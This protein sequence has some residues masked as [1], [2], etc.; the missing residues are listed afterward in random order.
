MK[1]KFLLISIFLL[2][3]F[4]ISCNSEL[5]A[6]GVTM[7]RNQPYVNQ[8]PNGNQNVNPITNQTA[9]D[10][11]YSNTISIS[12]EGTNIYP[13]NY[14]K[15]DYIKWQTYDFGTEYVFNVETSSWVGTSPVES[16]AA[17]VTLKASSLKIVNKLNTPINIRLK[18]TN[19]S[20][21]VTVEANSQPVKLSLDNLDLV[22]SDRALNIKDSS[23]SYIVLT[24]NNSLETKINSEDKN[25]IKSASNLIFDGS[26]SLTVTANSK[27][28]IA[29]DY[30]ICILNGKITVNV[31][32]ETVYTDEDTGE[33]VS[34]KGT[35]I[36]SLLG[37]VMLDGELEINGKNLKKGYESKGIK[38]DGFEAGTLSDESEASGMGWII[39][40]GGNIT[41]KTY[42]KAISAG[43][44][45]SEDDKPESTSNYPEPNVYLNGGVFNI[46]TYAVPR[47]DTA[48]L[49]GVSPEGIEAKNNLY[50][51]GGTYIIST[52]DDCINASNAVY[53]SGGMIYACSSANDSIDAGAEENE[54]YLYISGGVV[55]ALGSGQME[56]GLD[57]NS[58]SRFQFTGGTI[59]AMGGGQNNT[60]QASGTTAYTVSTSGLSAEKTYALVQND[61]LVLVFKVPSGYKFANSVLLGTSGL[62]EGSAVLLS[63]VTVSESKNFA[64]AVFYGDVN[65]S[66]GY[67][68]N[69]NV[70]NTSTGMR[71]GGM[72][73]DGMK[74]EKM[75]E[76]NENGPRGQFPE[77]RPF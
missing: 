59:V 73:E 4:F 21:K 22:S 56:T 50:I 40:D 61:N 35:A 70:S 30:V 55:V 72:R 15:S 28:G 39:I 8:L 77:R 46:T 14:D 31:A 71:E 62:S 58:N 3:I 67:S 54:G 24:G 20:F 49:E 33:T 60:P 38:V 34:D 26:G 65:V 36:K 2:F 47:D 16:G 63:E 18:G 41:V 27:N 37:F 45:E 17:E 9:N 7:T 12:S 23:V 68:N 69:V 42:G 66:G 1:K 19:E 64:G 5:S 29:S 53:I 44:K 57:C 10:T 6:L 74:E 48:F 76:F 51:T 43:W 25:V 52:T 11:V 13:S 32:E 75:R